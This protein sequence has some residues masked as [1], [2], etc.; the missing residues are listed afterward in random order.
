MKKLLFI[1][2]IIIATATVLSVKVL[3]TRDIAF[4]KLTE[5]Y[6]GKGLNIESFQVTQEMLEIHEGRLVWVINCW[7]N[8]NPP[9]SITAYVDAFSGQVVEAITGIV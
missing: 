2:L 1:T 4:N 9:I 6:N 3:N 8:I 7:G 5:Y